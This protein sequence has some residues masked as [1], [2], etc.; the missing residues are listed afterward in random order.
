MKNPMKLSDFR[1]GWRMLVQEPVYSTVVVLGLSVGFAACFLLLGFVRHSFSYDKQVP[2]AQQVYLV[3]T[4]FNIIGKANWLEMAPLPF[5]E[6]ARR[7]PMV[8]DAT[9]LFPLEVSMKAGARVQ[10]M[11]L[12]AVNS[13]FGAIFGVR[14]LEGDLR[15]ALS[16]PDS[17]ALTRSSA[18]RRFGRAAVL[19]ET[20]TIGGA[21]FRVAALLADPPAAS[22]VFYEALA[23]AGT[24]A[25]YDGYRNGVLKSWGQIGGRVYV[26]LRAGASPTALERE[27]QAAVDGSPLV[28]GLAP[29]QLQELGTRKALDVRLGALRDMYFDADTA[30]SPEASEHGD[31]RVIGGLAA[32]ALVILLLAA[33]NYVNLATVRTMRRQ[34]EIAVRKVLG[35]STGRIVAQFLAESTLVALIAAA[36]GMLVA[37]LLLPLFAELV[38]R[39]LDG[40]FSESNI[41]IALS[42]GVSTGLLAGLYPAWVALGV[43]PQH[44]LAGRGSSETSAGLWLRRALSVVQFSTAIG[45]TS[46]TLAMA[47]QT[48][49]ATN[50]DPGFD[51]AGML[52]VDLPAAMRG[53]PARD[54]LRDE[55]T[56]LS[57]VKGV[58]AAQFAIGKPFIGSH[59]PFVTSAGG[60]GN[61]LTLDV[62][63]N[64]FE[65]LAVGPIAGRL[66]DSKVDTDKSTDKVVINEG[67]ARALGYADAAQAVGKLLTMGE[68]APVHVV[69]IAPPIRYQSLHQGSRPMVYRLSATPLVLML[70]GDGDLRALETGVEAVLRRIAPDEVIPVRRAAS[71]FAQNYADDLRL[72]K[73]LGLASLIAIAIASFGI[74]VLATY[75]VQRMAR[76]IVLR[77][78]YGASRRAILALVGREFASLLG[79]GAAIALPIAALVNA[80]YLA[81]F[82]EQAPV[83]AW[84]LLGAVLLAALVTI[85]STM[86]HTLG[87]LRMAPAQ[88]L[89][90]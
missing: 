39:K 86:R 63:A 29:Q 69:G 50:R 53:S 67:A 48:H 10:K 79:L 30:D 7:S 9:M 77:K 62:S 8:A 74:Y 80:R 32:I 56:R 90:D 88:I 13:G 6:A 81:G 16:Q 31:L 36:L 45:L 76:Q 54:A 66:F 87:A 1:I 61:L 5:L 25:W 41:L 60:R 68:S 12:A 83:K 75:S 22:T 42:L 82:V 57:G 23:G 3:K 47:W 17:I 59:L 35:A 26:K 52:A 38:D 84:P 18:Q 19:G 14:A 72:A 34:R 44:T 55:L 85:V 70:R 2:E 51:A 78:L 71:Y 4:R 11:Q 46:V 24:S 40:I 43:H 73:L 15:A 28:A 64:F 89:R 58:A 27:L 21:T 65:V 20:V 33:T 37:W 49:Y